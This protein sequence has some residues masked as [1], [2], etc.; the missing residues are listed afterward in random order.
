MLENEYKF[1]EDNKNNF[2]NKYLNKY[3][4]IKGDKVLG[5][6]NS[7]EDAIKNAVQENELGTF[8]VQYVNE[9]EPQVIFRSRVK[10][11]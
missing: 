3:I 4:V 1:Y 8:L 5:V 6:F 11:A 10:Y 2:I 7:S 9:D